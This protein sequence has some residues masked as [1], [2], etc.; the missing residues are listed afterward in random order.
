M[1][2]ATVRRFSTLAAAALLGLSAVACATHPAAPP[3]AA[4]PTTTGSEADALP[5]LRD[6]TAIGASTIK[7]SPSPDWAVAAAGSVW[8]AGVGPGL[9]RYDATTGAVTGK[10]AI[11]SVCSAMDQG[12]GSIWAMSCDYSSPKLVRIDAATGASTAEIP[13][14]ARLPAE[15]SVGAGEGAVWLLTTGSPRQLLAVDPGTNTVART[16]PAPDGAK[17]VRAGFGAV[18]VSIAAPGQLVRL[19]PASGQVV[20]TIKV[21]PSASF[22]TIG[23]DA[24][25]VIGPSEATVSRVDPATNT[26]TAT[27]KVSSSAISG[28]DVAASE[29]AVWVRGTK[30]ALAVRINPQANAVVDRLGPPAGS[31]GITITDTSVWITAH[32]VQ[33]IWRLPQ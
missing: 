6:I 5:V 15:S 26:V 21:G 27:I 7:A 33:S 20:A 12:F 11:Y 16:L 13:M 22:L 29:D 25:W 31:G 23:P 28:G 32:D 14:P 30:D 2:A 9:Q 4:A 10:L 18:W 1:R 17:A 24:V 8:V 19:D 3:P